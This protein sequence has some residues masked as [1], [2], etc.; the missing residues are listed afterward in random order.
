MLGQRLMVI[1][2]MGLFT[3]LTQLFK[4]RI[5]LQEIKL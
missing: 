1:Q 5:Q 2:T 4:L 3:R